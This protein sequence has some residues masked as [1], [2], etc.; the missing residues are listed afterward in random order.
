MQKN[1][2]VENRERRDS[3]KS[4]VLTWLINVS[5]ITPMEALKMFGAFRLA[6]IIHKLRDEGHNIKTT[7]VLD[8]DKSYARYTYEGRK[9]NV[10]FS[11]TKI[12][13]W[14]NQN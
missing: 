5:G 11:K 2:E 4:K 6:A 8:G 12:L 10:D 14:K 9:E 1:N 13:N 3:Q 7:T